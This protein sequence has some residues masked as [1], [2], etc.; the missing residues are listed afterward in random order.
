MQPQTEQSPNKRSGF[1]NGALVAILLIV[2]CYPLLFLFAPVS[3]LKFILYPL[4]SLID[5]L[6]IMVIGM[7]AA[8]VWLARGIAVALY[9]SIS[10]SFVGAIGNFVGVHK[11]LFKRERRLAVVLVGC[12][13]CLAMYFVSR[14]VHFSPVT[15][16]PL[17]KY[18]RHADGKIDL[19]PIEMNFHPL[20]GDTLKPAT[21]EIIQVATKPN[22]LSGN[23]GSLANTSINN[24]SK[25]ISKPTPQAISK[26]EEVSPALP[27]RSNSK[28]DPKPLPVTYLP[29]TQS[30]NGFRFE[31]VDISSS[32][33]VTRCEVRITNLGKD[34]DLY[35][36]C[37]T[38]PFGNR[39][40]GCRIIDSKGK[41]RIVD[42]ISAGGKLYSKGNAGP[43]SWRLPGSTY[44]TG[45]P[46]SL[47]LYFDDMDESQ[48][49][50]PLI[51]LACSFESWTYTRLFKVQFRNVVMNLAL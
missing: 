33:G 17:K 12:A 15:G 5:A 49:K 10:F 8:D 18:Y 23:P 41:E 26:K 14:G 24:T 22:I 43:P 21:K 42:R 13:T 27:P 51:E 38:D 29:A 36:S 30:K 47:E 37:Y 48:D 25:P 32:D 7:T 16:E 28:E 11:Y 50:I 2:L 1:W 45:V 6:T 34:R 46:T 9:S 44:V 40:V 3:V 39:P 4:W 20:Y 19:F 35:V 31:L